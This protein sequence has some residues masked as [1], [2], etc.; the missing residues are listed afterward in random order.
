MIVAK[1]YSTTL[2]FL[3]FGLI[4]S[5]RADDPP[6]SAPRY[7][8]SSRSARSSRPG[9]SRRNWSS[10]PRGS[11]AT[12][13]SS[14]PI[15][16]TRRGSAARPRGGSG[17]R[18]GSTARS[19]SRSSST[20]PALKAKVKR[21]VDYILDHQTPDGWLGPVGDTQKHKPY[22]VWPLFVL[23]KAFMQYEQATGDP[24]I[25]PAML[26]ACRKIDEVTTKEPL[27]SWARF[28]GADLMVGLYWL[29]DKTGDK[30]VLALAEKIARQSYNWRSHFEN[31]DQ[32]P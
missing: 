28:R 11:A 8:P 7:S 27:Y 30:S 18:T 22:D 6:R 23:F 1:P 2:A 3:V 10:R 5:A 15:S 32:L 19:P 21:Y 26:K 25:V 12:S 24:R 4:A 13:T 17:R 20:T 16:R 31:F 9:G 14:G 29:H